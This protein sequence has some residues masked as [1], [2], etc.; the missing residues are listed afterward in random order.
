MKQLLLSLALLVVNQN[1]SGTTYYVNLN[2]TGNNSG[3]NWTNAFIDLQTAISVAVFGDHI[4]VAAGQY[5]PTSSNDRTISFV[6]KDGVNIYGGFI[7]TETTLAQRDFNLNITSLNG[8]IGA[9]GDNQDNSHNVVRANNISS[10]IT[11]DGF[12]IINGYS[13]SGYNG[14]GLRITNTLS[15]N[16]LLKN[17]FIYNNVATTYGAGLYTA[18]ANVKIEK[19]E[20]VNNQTDGGSGGAICNGNNNGGYSI[21]EIIDSKFKNNIARVGACL[22]NTVDYN[23][24]IIDRCIFTNN[25]GE[26]SVMEIDYFTN[27]KLLNSYWIGN[28]ID[29]FSGNLLHV[30]SSAISPGQFEMTNC[31][32]VH[33]FNVYI[34]T[35]Q[36]PIIE[37][38]RS[39][40]KIQNCLIY[41]NTTFNGVQINAIAQAAN[42]L[43]EGG[44][45]NGISIIDQDPLFINPYTG[46]TNNFDATLYDY[47][48]QNASPAINTGNNGFVLAQHA[49]DLDSL[50]RIQG[51]IVDM[52]CYESLSGLGLELVKDDYPF[53]CYYLKQDHSI[54]FLD[55]PSGQIRIFDIQGKL[56]YDQMIYQNE[57]AVLLRQGIYFI[58]LQ[59]GATQRI[60][61]E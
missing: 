37:L 4:W 54:R 42:S 40:Y 21:I 16:V 3:T 50:N 38:L 55:S 39:N 19:C 33:N 6:L 45:T 31:H 58:Q 53:F 22:Y 49:F 20:F 5:K 28:K 14:G 36:A 2:A 12:R 56:V 44:Y 60:L 15:G 25:T 43:I 1:I 47:H 18:G 27:C 59:D 34:N 61:I 10:N 32:L 29:D 13:G 46:I 41:G 23:S 57:M 8:D 11:L 26:I 17:C 51:T 48:L 30:T 7:G 52:G 24:L 9:A 35:I